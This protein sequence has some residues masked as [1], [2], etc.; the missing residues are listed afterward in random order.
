[1][2][3]ETAP[4][5]ENQEQDTTDWKSEARKWEQRAKDNKKVADD[6]AG[7]AQ[8][9]VDLEDAAKSVEQKTADRIAGLEK[10]LAETAHAA[11]VAR[12]QAK[13]SISD[14][15]A[16]LFL[17]GSDVDALEKQAARLAERSADQKKNGN[18]ARNEGD[19][20]SA[21]RGDEAMR[22]TVR[23]LFGNED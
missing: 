17:T 11:L 12:I 8:R 21:G 16:A 13:H 2:A 22:D 7:A 4:H 10:Q 5:G 15:D 3:E 14:D 1:M 6:N 19:A 23:R 20:K 18:V 9:L